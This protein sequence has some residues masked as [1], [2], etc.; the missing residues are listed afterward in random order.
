MIDE[1]GPRTEGIKIFIMA[2]VVFRVQ[3]KLP[4]EIV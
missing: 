3:E 2:V 1:D 4:V